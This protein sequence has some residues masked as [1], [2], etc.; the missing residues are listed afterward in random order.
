MIQSEK[1]DLIAAHRKAMKAQKAHLTS[2]FPST[3]VKKAKELL[4]AEKAFRDMVGVL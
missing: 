3:V 2:F 4:D 1:N